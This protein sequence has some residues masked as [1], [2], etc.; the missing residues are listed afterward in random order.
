LFVASY[1]LF[2]VGFALVALPGAP[3]LHVDVD[4]R[5]VTYR[6][7]W[8]VT[9]VSFRDTDGWGYVERG[10]IPVSANVPASTRL[11][12]VVAGQGG[13]DGHRVGDDRPYAVHINVLPFTPLLEGRE[14]FAQDVAMG[15]TAAARG[16]RQARRPIVIDVGSALCAGVR[17]CAAAVRGLAGVGAR[18][19]GAEAGLAGRYALG[20][21]AARV[22][23]GCSGLRQMPPMTLTGRTISSLAADLAAEKPPAAL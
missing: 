4:A 10:L 11:Y 22:V 3:L 17:D 9:R 16:A 7:L 14:S 23:D 12:T 15:L 19:L 2:L 21:T 20:G 18:S 13:F 6:R 5:G 1:V 8:H